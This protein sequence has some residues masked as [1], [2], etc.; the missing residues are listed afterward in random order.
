MR[1]NNLLIHNTGTVRNCTARIF[2][3][4][5]DRNSTD[6]TFTLIN[7]RNRKGTQ[8]HTASTFNSTS[9][10]GAVAVTGTVTVTVTV[11][12]CARVVRSLFVRSASINLRDRYSLSI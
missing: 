9:L 6:S 3:L 12:Y 1:L 10:E 7:D 8:T 2:T 4:I 11:T 5:N